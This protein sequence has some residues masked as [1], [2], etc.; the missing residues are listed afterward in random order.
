MKNLTYLGPHAAVVI[1]LPSG[2]TYEC[3][4]GA[5]LDLPDDLAKEFANRPDWEVT[6]QSKPIKKKPAKG[7]E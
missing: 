5:T 7:E 1:P 3:D 6:D 4:R 2:M